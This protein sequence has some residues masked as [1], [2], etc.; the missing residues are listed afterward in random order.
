MGLEVRA[1]KASAMDS[2]TKFGSDPAAKVGDFLLLMYFSR[3]VECAT[4]HSEA[5]T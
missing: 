5:N 3:F 4:R 2:Q 1:V